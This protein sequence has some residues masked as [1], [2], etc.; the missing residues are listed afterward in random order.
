ML[1]AALVSFLL[2]TLVACSEEG[3]DAPPPVVGPGLPPAVG[4]WNTKTL[5]LRLVRTLVRQID[6]ELE[7]GE[8]PGA[9]FRIRF[10]P[11]DS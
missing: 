1:R 11:S 7:L 2:L 6:G 4:L 8:P 5:G 3:R 10:P 9:E